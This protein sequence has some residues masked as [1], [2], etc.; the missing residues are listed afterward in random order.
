MK[1]TL[2]PLSLGRAEVLAVLEGRKTRLHL[3]VVLTGH[4]GVQTHHGVWRYC[5]QLSIMDARRVWQHRILTNRVIQEVCPLGST[6]DRLWVRERHFR[7]SGQHWRDLPHAVSPTGRKDVV[8]Y[9]AGFDRST[10]DLVKRSASAMPRWAS[11]LT[12]EVTN[13]RALQ[14]HEITDEDAE[15]DGM[16]RFSSS[17]LNRYWMGGPHQAHG[18]PRCMV[19]PRAAFVDIWSHRLGEREA[20]TDPF[21]WAVD[22]AVVKA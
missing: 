16:T 7:C 5:G 10:R 1:A 12:L 6:G 20:M 17:G 3:P 14:L 19:S 21:F 11:R 15:A 22:F 13:V 18:A 8:Y 4:D 2:R 9:Q